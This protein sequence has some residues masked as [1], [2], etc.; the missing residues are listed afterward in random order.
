MTGVYTGSDMNI[1][2]TLHLVL[3]NLAGE[4]T[5]SHDNLCWA[6]KTHWPA[7]SPLG[8]TRFKAQK[9]ISVVRNPIDVIASLCYLKNI[10]T[11]CHVTNE[12]PNEVDPMW[13]DCFVTK[14]AESMS[15]STLEMNRTVVPTIPTYY[16]RYE[17][18][19]LEPLSTLCELFCFLLEVPSIVGTVVEK[20]IQDY[21]V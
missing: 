14:T 7:D 11:M 19:I 6:T 10:L 13:W 17:D 8:S 20:R 18:L 4:E 15:R 16:V 1:D 2:T 5:V 3:G 9:C 21:C 12:K